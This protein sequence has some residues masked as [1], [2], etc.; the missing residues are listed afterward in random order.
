MLFDVSGNKR[1]GVGHVV[2]SVAL[3]QRMKSRGLSIRFLLA[4]EG[5]ATRIVRAQSLLV[6]RLSAARASGPPDVVLVD[7]PDTDAGRLRAH[8]ERWPSAALVVL[9]YYGPPVDGV[10][11]LINMNRWR[12]KMN[13]RW[14]EAC[15]YREG[16][17]YALLRTS[18]CEQR[19]RRRSTRDSGRVFLGFG[20]T[21]SLD[22]TAR[23]VKAIEA[24]SDTTHLEIVSGR[25]SVSL[26]LLERSGT[27]RRATFH[28][29][30]VNP[31]P[32]L[33]SCDVALVG[34][35]TMMM[36]AACIG[37]PSVVVPRTAAERMFARDFASAGAAIV[38]DP[39]SHFSA[40]RV[41]AAVEILM[42]QSLTRRKMSRAGRSLIDGRGA[43]RVI[44]IV[45]AV[46]RKRKP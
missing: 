36:E 38:V 3:A 10:D 42:T 46:A 27:I 28:R 18:F 29:S 37:I 33:A 21:D 25:R 17:E 44:H 45:R 22:W 12:V 30:V 31:A 23:T 6:Q 11:A 7:R 9:D 19:A 20:G 5:A 14:S 24:Q 41:A 35:G 15:M 39:G 16:L 13:R 40:R 8:R 4:G 26:N 43:D 1:S 34:G 32:L 2:R